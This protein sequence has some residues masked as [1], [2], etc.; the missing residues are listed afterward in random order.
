MVIP[1]PPPTP[2]DKQLTKLATPEILESP[3][4]AAIRRAAEDR[5][6]ILDIFA[7]LPK[8]DRNLLP[9]LQ[10]TVN[11]LVERVANLAQMIHRLEQSLDMQGLAEIDARIA[12]IERGTDTPENQRRL[13]LLK[14][15]RTTLAELVARRDALARQLESAGLALANLRLDLIK[16]RS[17]GI[18]S[19]LNDVSTATQ[20]ARALSREIGVVLD[21]AAEVRKL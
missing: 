8:P 11:A 12:E 10:P 1:P 6:A 7:H 2:T 14:R 18:Q 9:D 21:A 16:L 13:S 5:A 4:G 3:Y 17:S 19:A 20:E 15:Q